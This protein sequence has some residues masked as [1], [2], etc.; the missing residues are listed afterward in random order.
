MTTDKITTELNILKDKFI[1][2]Y[3][4]ELLQH[5]E[6]AITEFVG[7]LELN[8]LITISRVKNEK[9]K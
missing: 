9:V 6:W 7:W 8:E 4:S 5:G 1:D 2:L 3:R